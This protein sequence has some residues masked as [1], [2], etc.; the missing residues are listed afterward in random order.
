MR[1]Q[2]GRAQGD[3]TL[4]SEVLGG[5]HPKRSGPNEKAQK[6]LADIDVESPERASDSLL[7]LE[8]AGQDA[9]KEACASL[10]DGAP[11]RGPLNADQAISEA[12]S[13]EI[14]VSSPM[15]ARR[16]SLAIPN[17]RR[18]RLPDR[19]VLGLYVKPIEWGRPSTNTSAIGPDDSRAIIDR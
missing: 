12:P 10:E 5:K 18:A 17:A 4:Y 15:Q 2:A 11:T 7:T 13:A 1:K 14:T 9:S 19:L 3:T 8:G 6:S 16:S